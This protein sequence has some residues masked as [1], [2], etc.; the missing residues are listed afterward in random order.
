[1]NSQVDLT[2]I[3]AHPTEQFVFMDMSTYEEIRVQKDLAWAKYLTEGASVSL[4]LWNGT[5]RCLGGG[6]ACCPALEV[7][8]H[9]FSVI[10]APCM[11]RNKPF[12]Q[13]GPCMFLLDPGDLR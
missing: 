6:V 7:H 2:P 12:S 9:T 8:T 3:N 13:P 5:V 10:Q 11:G 1:M 4:V